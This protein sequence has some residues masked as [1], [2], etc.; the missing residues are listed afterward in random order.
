[1]NRQTLSTY[2]WIVICTLVLVVMIALAGPFG[3]FVKEAVKSTTTGIF[4]TSYTSLNEGLS[5]ATG[6][7]IEKA[8]FKDN[9]SQN[10]KETIKFSIENIGE[11]EVK[12][13]TTWKEWIASYK[14]SAGDNGIV[15]I[16]YDNHKKMEHGYLYVLIEGNELGDNQIKYNGTYPTHNDVIEAVE[17]S[18]TGPV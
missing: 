14:I 12:E 8:K 9:N 17:Y 4:D 7:T 18:V 2:G 16:G 6:T 15:W 13:G 5:D 11:F 3:L 1:M 10:T